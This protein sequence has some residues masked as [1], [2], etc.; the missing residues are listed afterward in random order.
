M[1]RTATRRGASRLC[2]YNRSLRFT[3]ALGGRRFIYSRYRS[4]HLCLFRPTCEELH[5][6]DS[7]KDCAYH[8]SLHRGDHGMF[9]ASRWLTALSRGSAVF[10][11]RR[12]QAHSR[13]GGSVAVLRSP[14]VA[15]EIEMTRRT[16]VLA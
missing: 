4:D 15:P 9:E 12:S 14:D 6:G 11:V 7:T 3:R 10:P 5:V 16:K 1:E 8:H 2:R 13:G